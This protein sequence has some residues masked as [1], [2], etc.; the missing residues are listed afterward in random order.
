MSIGIPQISFNSDFQIRG[1][2]TGAIVRLKGT[3]ILFHNCDTSPGSSGSPL[4]NR[5]GC[6]VGIHI[7]N[8]GRGIVNEKQAIILESFFISRIS[9]QSESQ[10]RLI[11]PPFTLI[12]DESNNLQSYKNDKTM[13]IETGIHPINKTDE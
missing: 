9:T 12:N 5:E 1:I 13:K 7:G 2:K 4:I 8:G 11:Q 10:L 3:S 6:V